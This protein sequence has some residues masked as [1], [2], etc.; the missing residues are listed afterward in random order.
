VSAE[1]GSGSSAPELARGGLESF[2]DP[3][4]TD[5][6]IAA[7]SAR[8][9]RFGSEEGLGI[10]LICGVNPERMPLRNEKQ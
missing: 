3:S 10:V 4:F 8:G 7:G 6:V 2:L 1:V 9:E 5:R